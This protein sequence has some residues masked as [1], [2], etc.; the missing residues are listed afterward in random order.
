L[1]ADAA[2]H[3]GESILADVSKARAS[4]GIRFATSANTV[5]SKPPIV[6]AGIP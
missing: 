4:P 1:L 2:R 3:A 5:K 6:G